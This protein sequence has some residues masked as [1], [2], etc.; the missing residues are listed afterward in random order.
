V[1]MTTATTIRKTRR[2]YEAG[3]SLLELLVVLG[4]GGLLLSYATLGQGQLLPHYRLSSAARQLV[5]DMRLLRTKAISQNGTFRMVFEANSNAYRAE[6]FNP[7][8]NAW[9]QYALYNRD[10]TTANSNQ[11]VALPASVV[12]ASALQV[13]FA[14]RGT[15]STNGSAS[16]TL[17]AP[18]PRSRTI[19]I[20][21]AGLI[22]VS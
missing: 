13:T 5:T 17:S 22:T 11:P 6:R 4:I 21:F 2:Q 14:P 10:A 20:N 12:T 16:V 19:A 3:F 15:V 7:A 18:G 1:T 9:E 8:T